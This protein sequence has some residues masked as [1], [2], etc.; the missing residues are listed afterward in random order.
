MKF[1]FEYLFKCERKDMNSLRI[2]KQLKQTNIDK[3]MF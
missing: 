2:R 1:G 3:L